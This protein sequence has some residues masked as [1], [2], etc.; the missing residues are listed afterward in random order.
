MIGFKRD[1]VLFLNND[2][3]KTIKRLFDV[4]ENPVEFNNEFGFFKT[5]LEE[6][7]KQISM[8]HQ[9]L[10]QQQI[11]TKQALDDK[12]ELQIELAENQNKSF[13]QRLLKK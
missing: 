5:Q 4:V 6:K 3:V 10:D 2:D 1:G 13:W 11:L 12:K 9:A 7:D 8:L